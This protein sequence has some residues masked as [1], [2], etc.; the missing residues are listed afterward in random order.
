MIFPAISDAV[1]WIDHR[2]KTEEVGW[3][4]CGITTGSLISVF[5]IAILTNFVHLFYFFKEIVIFLNSTVYVFQLGPSLS[6]II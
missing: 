6:A 2:L 3:V 4:T 1:R 5:V